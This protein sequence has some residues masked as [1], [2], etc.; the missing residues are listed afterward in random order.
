MDFA[1]ASSFVAAF[2][3]RLEMTNGSLDVG[4]ESLAISKPRPVVIGVFLASS[5]WNAESLHTLES[6]A[7]WFSF[8]LAVAPVSIDLIRHLTSHFFPMLDC[9]V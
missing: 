9:W 7:Q 8:A 1:C 5:G 4:P 6:S 3:P 2:A